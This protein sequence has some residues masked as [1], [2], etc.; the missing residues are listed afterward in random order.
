MFCS[1]VANHPGLP[2][3]SLVTGNPLVPGKWEWI[4]GYSNSLTS[5]TEHPH[6]AIMKLSITWENVWTSLNT[7]SGT[8]KRH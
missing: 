5:K 8:H 7:E 4:V 1:G 6:K 3:K 2:E